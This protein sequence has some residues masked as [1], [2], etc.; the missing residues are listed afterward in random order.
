MITDAMENIIRKINTEHWENRPQ[1]DEDAGV[2]VSNEKYSPFSYCGK[3]AIM[4]LAE[5]ALEKIRLKKDEHPLFTWEGDG[6][7]PP[8]IELERNFSRLEMAFII[9]S[10]FLFLQ[11]IDT[12]YELR[13]RDLYES[14]NHYAGKPLSHFI[15]LSKEKSHKDIKAIR[16]I[17]KKLDENF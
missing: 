8:P 3:F 9:Q 11:D 14:D 12:I 16:E 4:E 5:Q 6:D 1:Y 13:E 7:F 17:I 15:E 2:M 10:I